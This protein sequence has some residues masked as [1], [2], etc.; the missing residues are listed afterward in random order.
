MTISEVTRVTT[1]DLTGSVGPVC[2]EAAM[3][4]PGPT[5]EC[6][7]QITATER[8]RRA[9]WRGIGR[10]SKSFFIGVPAS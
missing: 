3:H 1:A 7:A 6:Q 8:I 4:N 5:M 9:K 2:W 10:L